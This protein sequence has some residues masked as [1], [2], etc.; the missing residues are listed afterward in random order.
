MRPNR[1]RIGLILAVPAL[2]AL[3]FTTF[4]LHWGTEESAVCAA[5]IQASFS[6][7][8]TTPLD[9]EPQ[10][11]LLDHTVPGDRFWIR[12]FHAE[13]L[14]I[15]ARTNIEYSFKN[16]FIVRVPAN[17]NLPHPYTLISR[18]QLNKLDDPDFLQTAEGKDLN[19]RLSES[20]GVITLSRVGFDAS[21]KHA[22]M[23]V[24]LTYCGLCGEGM[25][26][27]LSKTNGVWRVERQSGTWIS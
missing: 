17:L 27:Y 13:E 22:V 5:A 9:H 6:L 23:Y 11:L 3:A 24:Q 19:R 7:E 14:G 1:L 16:L 4:L 20:W 15:G 25:F 10:F 8:H 18:G 2:A 21:H 26:L 12:R